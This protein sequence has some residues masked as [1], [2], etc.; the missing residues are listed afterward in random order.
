[1]DTCRT[2]MIVATASSA[3]AC[4]TD[5]GSSPEPMASALRNAADWAP[6][7]DVVDIEALP[8]DLIA[9]VTSG[10]S[11]D[12]LVAELVDGTTCP[13]LQGWATGLSLGGFCGYRA[14]SVAPLDD[15]STDPRFGK[16]TEDCL[17]VRPQR[18]SALEPVVGMQARDAFASRVGFLSA[19]ELEMNGNS[20]EPFRSPVTVAVVDTIPELRPGQPNS[21]HGENLARMISS[22]ACPSGEASCAVTVQT[23]LGLPRIDFGAPD[24]VRGGYMGRFTDLAR[25]VVT[26]VDAWDGAG[27]LIVNLSVGWEFEIFGGEH[28]GTEIVRSAVQYAYCHGALV[29]ASAGNDAGLCQDGLLAPAVLAEEYAPG[30]ARCTALGV[31]VAEQVLEGSAP[32]VHAIGGLGYGDEDMPGSRLGAHTR[33]MANASHGMGGDGVLTTPLTGTSVS[34]AAVSG[35]AAMV[36]SY[37]PGM[38]RNEVM[39]A[40]YQG[41]QPLGFEA[42]VSS[43]TD[44]GLVSSHRL[45]ICGAMEHACGLDPNCGLNL[46]CALPTDHSDIHSILVAAEGAATDVGSPVVPAA[47]I[48][49]SEQSTCGVQH[50]AESEAECARLAPDPAAPYADPQ[51]GG[52]ICSICGLDG[53]TLTGSLDQHVDANTVEEVVLL[54]EENGGR[55]QTRYS[56]GPP[57]FTNAGILKMDVD[58][59]GL[60]DPRSTYTLIGVLADGT[61]LENTIYSRR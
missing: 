15:P 60:A 34:A 1:M 24:L 53:L 52:T 22:L 25:G 20:T 38:S 30:G 41:G 2:L 29:V 50:S 54:I 5:A 23:A 35:A 18:G 13:D 11:G 59:P 7:Y 8:A 45:S 56:L 9:G 3:V 32:L 43:P 33:L 47:R 40:L 39:D 31:P 48:L 26:A 55:S 10:C 16:V 12:R 6:D 46:S 17:A 4:G 58:A 21:E 49:C 44:T 14:L 28:P 57:A 36:W 19:M 37:N 61:M 42:D 27:H 51:P